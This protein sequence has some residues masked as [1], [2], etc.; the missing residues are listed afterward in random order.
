M[1]YGPQFLY[2]LYLC[3]CDNDHIWVE[4]DFFPAKQCTQCGSV[5]FENDFF[6]EPE[7]ET[8]RQTEG[9]REREH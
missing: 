9:G 6:N 5:P 2:I 4:N 8:D 1:E 3:V 7:L